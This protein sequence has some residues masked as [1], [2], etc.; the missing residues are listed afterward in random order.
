M[1]I[2]VKLIAATPE[3]D[4]VVAAA[5][6]ICYSP[7]GAAQILEGLDPARTASFLKM[8]REAG[9]LSPFEHASFTFAVEG[10]S[11]VATHQL[12]RHRLAS[13]SQQSQ[14]YVEMTGNSCIVPPSV[15]RSE[16]ALAF[17]SAQ[18]EA[19]HECY[20]KLV[21]LGIPRED[22]RFILP[23]GAETRLVA[24]MNAR[25]LHHFFALRLCRRAQ[26]EIRETAKEMLKAVRAAAP[27][28]FDSA[29]PSC[30]VAGRCAEAH[31]CG[32]PYRD[33]EQLLS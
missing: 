19:A 32:E 33:M 31:P 27:Q 11:R 9:H 1:P 4:K 10:L 24:T 13:Y 28:L 15:A 20:T 21:A 29:G 6:K 2:Y 18:A 23:H 12:V 5:A 7:S 17:F 14:R 26:W 8:L 3:A 22:A 30:V 25:E 16:E